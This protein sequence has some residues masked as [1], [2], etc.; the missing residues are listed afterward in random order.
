VSN[1]LNLTTT[2]SDES[3]DT[4]NN[5]K[6]PYNGSKPPMVIVPN[7]KSSTS[8]KKAQG[9]IELRISWIKSRAE[10]IKVDWND[11]GKAPG[12]KLSLKMEWDRYE[13]QVPKLL[14][15]RELLEEKLLEVEKIESQTVSKST[16][17][18]ISFGE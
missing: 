1:H 2:G 7:L 12:D 11:P 15:K 5:D 16:L 4:N 17:E 14:K 3:Q 10:V 9:M 13:E 6:K 18:P 8:V